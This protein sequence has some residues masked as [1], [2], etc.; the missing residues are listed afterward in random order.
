MLAWPDMW[1]LE[2]SLESPSTRPQREEERHGVA[3]SLQE[4][5]QMLR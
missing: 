5:R 1:E 3:I 2:P 4:G